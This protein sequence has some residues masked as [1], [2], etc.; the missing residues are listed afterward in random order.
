MSV[1]EITCDVRGACRCPSTVRA[2]AVRRSNGHLYRSC[3]R[4]LIQISALRRRPARQFGQDGA[5]AARPSVH[6]V[7][8]GRAWCSHADATPDGRKR[9][10]NSTKVAARRRATGT[11]AG[12]KTTGHLTIH[13]HAA[14]IHGG[15]RPRHHAAQNQRAEN[16]PSQTPCQAAEPTATAAS[17]LLGRQTSPRPR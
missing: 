16:Q 4:G 11:P 15:V 14:S 5:A 10:H 6:S 17:Q 2:G 1:Q 12:R 13:G 8:P 3:F 7:P 9:T